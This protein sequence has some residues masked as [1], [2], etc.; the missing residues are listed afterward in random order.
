MSL[1]EYGLG[2]R[3]RDVSLISYKKN[4]KLMKIIYKVLVLLSLS[5]MEF[6]HCK[7]R[8]ANGFGGK[9]MVEGFFVWFGGWFGAVGF[10][11][12]ADH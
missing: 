4:K 1:P 12:R 9:L 7:S 11:L 5:Y 10:F 6:H 2:L 8:P 3:Y